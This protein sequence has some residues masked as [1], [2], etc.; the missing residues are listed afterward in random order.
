M[1]VHAHTHDAIG[2]PGLLLRSAGA[3]DWLVWLVT[4]GHERR[5]R[6]AMLRPAALRR[7]E[8]VLDI[9]CGTGSLALLAKRQVGPDGRVVGI[10]GSP[11]MIARARRKTARANAE[12]AFEVAPA[13]ALPFADCSFDVVLSTL[14][15]HHLPRPSRAQLGREIRRVLKPGG[16]V[17]AVD[18]ARGDTKPRGLISRVHARHGATSPADLMDPLADA[19]LEIVGSGPLGVMDLHFALG[20][21]PGPVAAVNVPIEPS[22]VTPAPPRAARSHAP[23][24]AVALIALVGLHLGAGTWIARR[25]SLAP[26][27]SAIAVLAGVVGG[28]VLLKAALFVRWRRRRHSS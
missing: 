10:D 20:R 21:A 27:I 14:V 3:Y 9:G 8:H 2:H 11:E 13:Q 5:F 18:F 1:A 4:F 7:G 26:S 17:L 23:L 15:F 24:V 25:L 28:A 22:V 6:E 19:G 12:V 16:R